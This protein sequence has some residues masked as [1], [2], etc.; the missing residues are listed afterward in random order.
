MSTMTKASATIAAAAPAGAAPRRS[1]RGAGTSPRDLMRALPWIAPA[2]VLIFGVVLFPAGVMFYNSTRDISQ[3]GVDRGAAGF[4]N[5]RALLDFG[6]IWGVLGRTFI[7]V[8][9]VVVLT[10]VVSLA[11]AQLLNKA[12]PGRQLV[13]MAVI[14]PWAASVVMTTLVV[15][16]GLDPFYGI[17]NEALVQ[18]GV[19]DAPYGWTKN[20][21]SAFSWS[22]GIAVFVSLPFTTYTILAGLQTLPADVFEAAKVDGAGRVR[23]YVSIVLPQLRSALAVAILINIINVFNSLPILKVMTGSIPG[24]DADTVM[25]LI[26]KYIQTDHKIDVASALSVVSFLIVLVI[27]AVYVKVVKPMKEV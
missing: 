6:P 16:Y 19:I 11:L 10:V 27:V 24:Y 25:T 23:T 14:V 3:S 8:V 1:R 5:Y 21:A 2:L 7:W 13:R 20:A 12:F 9:A 4:D 15:Y 18:L 17:I 26:F 22:I